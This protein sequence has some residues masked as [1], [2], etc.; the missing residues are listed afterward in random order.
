MPTGVAAGLPDH[1]VIWAEL[2][3]H[4]RDALEERVRPLVLQCH[5]ASVRRSPGSD[6]TNRSQETFHDELVRP[7]E[8]GLPA[9]FFDRFVVNLHPADAA[10]LA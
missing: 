5:E 8:T 10:A 1:G 2:E 7:G 9:R 6:V 3:F 4:D